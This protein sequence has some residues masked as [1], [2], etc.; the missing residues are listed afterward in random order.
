MLGLAIIYTIAATVAAAAYSLLTAKTPKGTL[1]RTFAAAGFALCVNLFVGYFVRPALMGSFWGQGWLIGCLAA[2]VFVVALIDIFQDERD[3]QRT[4][5]ILATASV[6]LA[7][8][9][10]VGNYLQW[11]SNSLGSSNAARWG[12]VLKAKASSEVPNTDPNHMVLVT[13]N[14]AIFKATQVMGQT[15]RSTVYKVD[16]GNGARQRIKGHLFYVFPVIPLDAQAQIGLFKQK[17]TDGLGYIKV[18]LEDPN[19][20]AELVER[21]LLYRLD[22]VFG[23]NALRVIYDA[24]YNDGELADPTVEIDDNGTPFITVTMMRPAFGNAFRQISKVITLNMETGAISA[25]DPAKAPA[26]ID[27]IVPDD[28]AIDL[29]REWGYWNDKRS[30]EQWNIFGATNQ[31]QMQPAVNT[32]LLLTTEAGSSVWVIP[33]TSRNSADN[34][35]VGML[36]VDTRVDDNGEVRAV[37]YEEFRGAAIGQ[38]V[39]KAFLGPIQ[40]MPNISISTIQFYRLN[41]ADAWVAIYEQPQA[42][43]TSLYRYA[44]MPVRNSAGANV[45]VAADKR[46]LLQMFNQTIASS[47][48]NGDSVSTRASEKPFSGTIIGVNKICT[49]GF[50]NAGVE[51]LVQVTLS[52]DPNHIYQASL[53]D[54]PFLGF[55]KEGQTL[56]GTFSATQDSSVIRQIINIDEPTSRK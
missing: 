51:T 10:P 26:F 53:K 38:D 21:P 27:R 32:P 9:I 34:S 47:G 6:L 20:P 14:M 24:G 13:K 30:T 41:G 46:S 17:V 18:S 7:L 45:S 44:I 42:I 19:Q 36:L 3:S 28:Y 2:A 16:T 4:G 55:V 8:L 29:A 40:N 25:F 15:G 22:G 5:S 56:S 1:V 43:G 12:N 49:G 54:A 35:S 37:F 50:N 11:L 48:R 31:Y 39:E 33:M 52:S 23:R